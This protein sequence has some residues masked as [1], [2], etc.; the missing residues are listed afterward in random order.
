MNYLSL[1]G[2]TCGLFSLPRGLC[3]YLQDL[4]EA[5]AGLRSGCFNYFN[6]EETL[7]SRNPPSLPSEVPVPFHTTGCVQLIDIHGIN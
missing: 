4:P 6:F 2:E 5:L 3:C 7:P 1:P